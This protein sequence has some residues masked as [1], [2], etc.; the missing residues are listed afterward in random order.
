[1]FR[2][3]LASQARTPCSWQT[4]R[5]TCG[6]GGSVHRE[7]V[8]VDNRI[9]RALLAP[10]VGGSVL[11]VEFPAVTLGRTLVVAA[12]LHDTWQRKVAT[13]TV[14]LEV[15]VDGARRGRLILSTRSGWSTLA[16]DTATHDGRPASVRFE[17]SSAT[18]EHLMSAFAAEAR[19]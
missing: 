6:G 9:R 11:A 8:E 13:G 18:P 4:D 15:F 17:L 12:G 19:R 1:V 10:P 16:I 3:A 2:W 5:F 14:D 7:L